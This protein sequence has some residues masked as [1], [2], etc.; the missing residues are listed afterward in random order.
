MLRRAF[1]YFGDDLAIDL[2]TA[3]TLVAAAGRGVVINEPSVIAV[4]DESRQILSGGCAIGHLAK[5]MLGRAPDSIS[6]VRPVRGGVINDFDLCESMLRYFFTKVQSRRWQIGP[7]VIIAVP[8]CVSPVE[9]RAVFHSARSAG[10][11]QVLLIPEAKAAA[12]GAGLPI[13]EPI[14]NLLVDIGGGTTEVAIISLGD[15]VAS[16]S[17]R[18]GGDAMDEAIREY[19]RD[20]YSL[21]VGYPTAERLRIELG[22]AY[23]LED[24]RLDEVSGIDVISGLPRR[25]TIT[26]EEIRQALEEPLY[27]IIRA[28]RATIDGCNPDLAADLV[29]HG[30]VLCGG[31]ALLRR[32][33]RFIAEQTGLP[34]RVAEDPLTT[35]VRGALVCLEGYEQW[36]DSLESSEAHV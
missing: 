4:H 2:G 24:E 28:I 8:G 34:T 26:S 21:S 3:N 9:R 23:P 11:R 35:V 33:D 29:E 5:L 30:C 1:S 13:H 25:A 16:E 20:R 19:L 15:T 7:R 27:R 17:I 6:V 31:G 36:R 12:I 22:S 18:I 10:A 32:M 14:A